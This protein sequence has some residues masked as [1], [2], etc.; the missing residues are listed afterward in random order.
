MAMNTNEY[1]EKQFNKLW[2]NLNKRIDQTA[3][4]RDIFYNACLNS[5]TLVNERLV[6][7]P[8]Y[9][10]KLS[11]YSNYCNFRFE[12][13]RNKDPAITKKDIRPICSKEWKELSFE[14]RSKWSNSK[15]TGEVQ[16][17]IV[18]KKACSGYNLFTKDIA[19]R[20]LNEGIDLAQSIKNASLGW[21]S[22]TQDERDDWNLKARELNVST[23]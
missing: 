7:I 12:E 6:F 18:T 4:L 2:E 3:E 22:L 5:G 9:G 13:L 1:F 15:G 19:K 21:K 16:K 23:P 8:I 11:N 14:D 17:K 10:T 20:R